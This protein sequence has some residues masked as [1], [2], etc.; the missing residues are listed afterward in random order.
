M[1]ETKPLRLGKVRCEVQQ[2]GIRVALTRPGA[3]VEEL[4][5]PPWPGG[6]GGV[7]LVTSPDERSLAVFLFSGQSSQ[8]FELF[9]LEPSLRHL[10]SVPETWGHGDAPF[11]SRRGDLVAM[12]MDR[13]R[14]LSGTDT[15]FEDVQ[16]DDALDTVLVDWGRVWW[17]RV[18]EG[19]PASF[20]V[21]VEVPR[22][23]NVDELF[24]WAPYDVGSFDADDALVLSLPWGVRAQTALPRSEPLITRAPRS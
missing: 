23:L 24:D 13:E 16:A 20:T 21:A 14:K 2:R 18:A 15:W 8:G 5:L 19:V 6:V 22:S 1:T 7:E 11:F 17:L 10:A 4:W 9:S 12:V 3:P